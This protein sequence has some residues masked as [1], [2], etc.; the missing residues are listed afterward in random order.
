MGTRRKTR[1]SMVLMNEKSKVRDSNILYKVQYPVVSRRSEN[2]IREGNE[3]DGSK[4]GAHK[5]ASPI[6]S[7]RRE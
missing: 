7:T 2:H 4:I 5:Q 6:I 1:I 3:C